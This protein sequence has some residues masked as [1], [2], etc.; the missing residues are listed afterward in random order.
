M[1]NSSVGRPVQILLVEDSPSDAAMIV[2]ALRDARVA[3]DLTTVNNGESALEFLLHRGPFSSAPRPDLVLLDLNLPRMDGRDVLAAIKSEANLA[4][5]PVVVLTS[6]V[7]PLDVDSAYQLHA[8]AYV[9]KPVGPDQFFEAV[10]RIEDFWLAIVQLPGSA[11]PTNGVGPAGP[12]DRAAEGTSRRV[13]LIEDNPVDA[14]VIMSLSADAN[15]GIDWTVTRSLAE[16]RKEAQSASYDCILL[17]LDLPDS[18]ADE[19][20]KAAASFCNDVP[21]IVL[22]GS[23]D[24]ESGPTALRGGA[25]DFLIKGR[26]DGEDLARAIDYAIHRRL[27]QRSAFK[28]ELDDANRRAVESATLLDAMHDSAPVGLA[29]VD[30][31]YRYVRVNDIMAAIDGRPVSSHI[32]RTMSEVSPALWAHLGP[33]LD[34]IRA[35]QGPAVELE[36]RM[37]SAEDLGRPHDWLVTCYPVAVGGDFIGI[38]IVVADVTERRQAVHAIEEMNRVLHTLMHADA[39]VL[40]AA[41]EDAILDGM[42][43]VLVEDGRYSRA[44]V[45]VRRDDPEMRLEELSRFGRDSGLLRDLVAAAPGDGPPGPMRQALDTNCTVALQNIGATEYPGSVPGILLGHGFRSMVALPVRVSG[46]LFGVLVLHSDAVDVFDSDEVALLEGLANDLGYGLGSIRAHAQRLEFLSQLQRA[47]QALIEAMS[48]AVEVRDP[49]TAGHQRRVARLAEAIAIELG[50]DE[51]DVAGIRAAA[52]VHDLGKIA[53]P[54]EILTRPGRLSAVEYNIV[55]EHPAIGREIISRADL[56]WPVAEMVFQHHERWDGSGY[57]LGLKGTSVLLGSRV[58][59][60]ADVVEA[61]ASNRPYR[62][63][64]GLT[65]ALAEIESGSGIRYDAEVVAGCVR[66]FSRDGY[67]LTGEGDNDDGAAGV[68]SAEDTL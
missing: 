65:A 43:R 14:S 68:R 13:L 54:A 11:A 18:P 19:T 53:I 59:A 61:M 64:A 31:N 58:I 24:G 17:D 2:A 26:T 41:D 52:T 34:R 36:V 8:N 35:D 37:D 39:A 60:V 22:T 32:G 56:P 20:L 48:A 67:D 47:Q 55:K 66:L 16:G 45:V 1:L 42:C 51:N 5:I 57:P 7:S 33:A 9:K 27:T 30:G 15:T 29:F 49:Y 44:A 50:L 23:R 40:H 46:T 21:I 28:G 10:R 63:A 12:Q 62:P 4:S 3:N 25:E 6:S 38:G